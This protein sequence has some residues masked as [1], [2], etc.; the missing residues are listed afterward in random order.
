VPRAT[1]DRFDLKIS[2][3]QPALLRPQIDAAF[4]HRHVTFE[5]LGST[6]DEL[7]Y[8]VT[9]PFAEKIGKASNT[10]EALDGGGGTSVEWQIKRQKPDQQ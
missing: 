10:I 3:R 1:R 2:T 7:Q 5:L 8:E 4:R 6:R 9:M